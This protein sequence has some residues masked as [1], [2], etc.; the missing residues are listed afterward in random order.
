[1]NENE[2]KNN[3]EKVVTRSINHI[4]KTFQKYPMYYLNEEDIRSDLYRRV[5]NDFIH[6]IFLKNEH[7][8]AFESNSIH[9]DV[10]FE[11]SGGGK[12]YPYPDLLIY[13]CKNTKNNPILVKTDPKGEKIEN[14]YFFSKY[15]DL[16]NKKRVIIEI[17]FT[18]HSLNSSKAKGV[19]T[20]LKKISKW[21]SW[22]R[23]MLYFDRS[24]RLEERKEFIE[25]V[26]FMKEMKDKL[27]GDIEFYY[28][29]I[30]SF[31]SSKES[32]FYQYINGIRIK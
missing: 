6:N 26:D 32:Q 15:N 19:L 24:N 17:K 7:T 8:D 18:D 3:L 25:I 2:L 14:A 12:K 27:D 30:P 9:A 29:G 31:N 5:S 1:M 21:E 23:Y 28:L 20:D 22:K 11:K 4:I 16:Q 10:K 13:F